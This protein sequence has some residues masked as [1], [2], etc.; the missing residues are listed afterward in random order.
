MR[1]I[2]WGVSGFAMLWGTTW[3]VLA[4]FDSLGPMSGWDGVMPIRARGGAFLFIVGFWIL[5]LLLVT[6]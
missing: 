3:L 1:E 6:G 4:F 5:T 2:L